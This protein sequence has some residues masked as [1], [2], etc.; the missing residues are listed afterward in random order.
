MRQSRNFFPIQT[1]SA[2]IGRRPWRTRAWSGLAVLVG[3]IV[4]SHRLCAEGVL[5]TLVVP[6]GSVP[7]SSELQIG[8]LVANPG[9]AAADFA[10]PAVLIGRLTA[11]L[12]SWPVQL[13]A[14]HPQ[15]AASVAAGLFFN[16]AYSLQLPPELQGQVILEVSEGLPEPVRAVL[17]VTAQHTAEPAP[18]PEFPATFVPIAS[19]RTAASTLQKTFIDHFSALDPSYFIYGNKAPNAKFQFSFKYRLLTFDDG[20]P[21]SPE[22]TVQFGYSQRSLWDINANSSPFYDTSYMPSLFYQY[23]A[24]A[25]SRVQHSGG[26]TW[27]GFQTGYQ[28]ESNGQDGLASRSMND[29]FGRAGVLLGRPNSWHAIVQARIFD[30]VGGLSDNPRIK[31]Y[32]GYGDWQIVLAR[33]SGPSLTYLGHSG[34]SFNHFTGQFD[35][36]IPVKTKFLNFATYFLIQYFEGYGESLRAYTSYSNTVRAGISLVR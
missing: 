25:P 22:S 6:G 4:G 8:V 2:R 20:A 16:H 26:A 11:G 18:P 32:R 27:L 9:T 17:T 10:A 12:R 30:Y 19:N 24:P 23:L 3:L 33:G 29:L 14:V 31:E 13:N 15:E 35:L 34:R 36:N 7:A 21:E 1:S 28:H 5:I